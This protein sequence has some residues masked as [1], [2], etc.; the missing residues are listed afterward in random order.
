MRRKSW[1]FLCVAWLVAVTGCDD[2]VKVTDPCG[3]GFIDP[4]EACDGATLNGESCESLGFYIT[5]GQLACTADC[6]YDTTDCGHRCGDG[7]L[8]VQEDCDD[9]NTIAGDGCDLRCNVE[10]GWTCTEESPSVCEP[11]CGDQVLV[12]DEDCEQGLL[13]GATCESLGFEPGTLA[14]TRGCTFDTA[15]CGV[16]GRVADHLVVDAFEGIPPDAFDWVFMNVVAYYGCSPFGAQLLTGLGMLDDVIDHQP[17]SMFLN[18]EADLGIFGDLTWEAITRSYLVDNPETN[19][20]MWSWGLGLSEATSAHVD[21]YLGAMAQLEADFPDVRF[22]YMTGP[23]DGTGDGGALR[24]NN[25]Q[26]RDFCVANGKWLFDFEDIESWDPDGVYHPDDGAECDWCAAWMTDHPDACPD[27]NDSCPHS[28]CFNCYR[29][30]QALW[31]LL[32]RIA[33]WE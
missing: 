3:D 19:L 6:R 18:D 33:G 24:T 4:G 5:T 31:W 30:G 2:S 26:I 22:V 25:R 11:I 28:H 10:E 27:C 21:L 12:G 29:K 14:C 16:L 9:G 7:L 20:V 32:A 1:W 8:D 15:G 23:L 17:L 13:N